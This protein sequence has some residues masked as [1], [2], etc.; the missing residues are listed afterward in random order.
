MSTLRSLAIRPGHVDR[1]KPRCTPG[2]YH[3]S[4]FGP[5]MRSLKSAGGRTLA[6][7][8]FSTKRSSECEATARLMAAAPDLLLALRS[9][10]VGCACGNHAE[11]IGPIGRSQRARACERCAAALAAIARAEG[12]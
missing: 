4:G 3:V 10:V 11:G 8:L 7:V 5:R 6:Y 9:L 2:P 12:F 1:K